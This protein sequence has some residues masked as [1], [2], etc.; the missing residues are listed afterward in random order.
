[1]PFINDF[2]YSFA[3]S[4]LKLLPFKTDNI[5]VPYLLLSE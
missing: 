4:I 2:K 5:T 1:M 3:P